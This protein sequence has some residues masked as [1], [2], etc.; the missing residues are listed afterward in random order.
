[1]TER[2]SIPVG[3]VPFATVALGGVLPVSGGRGVLPVSGWVVIPALGG[4]LPVS[5]WGRVGFC[6]GDR[7][8]C[9]GDVSLHALR[10]TE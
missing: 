8:V 3:C 6:P 7:G 5:G 10:Q 9:P 1:M 4:M 2:E